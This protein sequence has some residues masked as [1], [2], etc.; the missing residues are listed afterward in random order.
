M[1]SQWEELMKEELIETQPQTS[2]ERNRR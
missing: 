2:A 1:D